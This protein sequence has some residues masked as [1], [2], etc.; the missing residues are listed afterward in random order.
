MPAVPEYEYHPFANAFPMMSEQEYRDLVADIKAQGQHE[1]IWLYQGKILDGRN[2]DKAC[3]QLG[4]KPNYS[5]FES[6]D[7]AAVAFVIS[8]N[9]TRR[10]L[11]VAQKGIAADE[12]A[13]LRH[14]QRKSDASNEASQT[15]AAKLLHVSRSTVQRAR[16]VR[17]QGTPELVAA[18]KAGDVT[19]SAAVAQIEAPNGTDNQ[20]VPMGTR[21]ALNGHGH[22]DEMPLAKRKPDAGAE[23]LIDPATL[24][25]SA[26]EKLAI[27][28][29]QMERRLQASYDEAVRAAIVEGTKQHLEAI[30]PHYTEMERRYR[31][32][33][34]SRTRGIMDRKTYRLILSCLHTDSRKSVSDE[35][36]NDAFNQFSRMETKV[37]SEKDDP[38]PQFKMP[39]TIEELNALKAKVKAERKAKRGHKNVARR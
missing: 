6:D 16:K 26:Q 38:T 31:V 7:A 34:E 35:K 36:L 30:L 18:V 22:T 20:A 28:T 39:N 21:A 4:I 10:H 29:R 33:S 14:G 12:L 13:T 25:I 27:A 17:Q 2:R 3:R 37:M 8:M 19:L 24:S 1:P 32:L 5:D 9:L 23:P 15:E 11:T